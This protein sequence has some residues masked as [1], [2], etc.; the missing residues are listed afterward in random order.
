MV[1]ILSTSNQLSTYK[2]QEVLILTIANMSKGLDRINVV[3]RR[4]V[5]QNSPFKF[6]QIF[7]TKVHLLTPIRVLY[8]VMLKYKPISNDTIALLSYNI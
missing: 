3:M 8:T 6:P 7:Y 5:E 4:Y 1:S 2:F